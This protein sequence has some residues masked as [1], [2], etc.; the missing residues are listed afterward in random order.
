MFYNWI[1]YELE[2][3]KMKYHIPALVWLILIVVILLTACGTKTPTN[4]GVVP[5]SLQTI[6][7]DAEGI[8]RTAGG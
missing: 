4:L 7:A 6:E 1:H 8:L 2:K 3:L 5:N